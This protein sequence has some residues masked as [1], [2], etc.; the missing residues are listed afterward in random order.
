M[1]LV[2][3]VGFHVFIL[4]SHVLVVYYFH[5]VLDA[6]SPE[7]LRVVVLRLKLVQFTHPLHF[8]D[9]KVLPL[10]ARSSDIFKHK[11]LQKI[12]VHML[13]V[14]SQN[15]VEVLLSLL[16]V[17]ILEVHGSHQKPQVVVQPDLV[18]V[19]L[20]EKL[21]ILSHLVLECELSVV[22]PLHW[23]IF[24]VAFLLHDDNFLHI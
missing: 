15:G 24:G 21:G 11:T 17:A 9:S 2:R 5:R 20:E 6:L 14:I 12:C 22:E 19:L 13:P 1:H 23:V 3:V 18:N 7:V 10:E 4:G 16:I 8:G